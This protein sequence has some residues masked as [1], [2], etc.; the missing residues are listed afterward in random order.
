MSEIDLSRM[1]IARVFEN[2]QSYLRMASPESQASATAKTHAARWLAC[3]AA[4]LNT[5]IE[6]GD[7]DAIAFI[8][9]R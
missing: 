9:E 4:E 6:R 1:K 5:R 8:A 2:L 7:P 3:Y